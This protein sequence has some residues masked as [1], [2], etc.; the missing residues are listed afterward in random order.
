MLNISED[1]EDLDYYLVGGA[2]RDKIMGKKPEDEDFVV[3]GETKQS[4]IDRGFKYIQ[5]SSSYPVFLDSKKREFAL[6]RA[7]ESK[8]AGYGDFKFDT[9]NVSLEEDLRRRDFTMNAIAMDKNGNIVDPFNGR[10]DINRGI[11]RHVSSAFK[12]D[13]LRVFRMARFAARFDFEVSRTTIE[14]SKRTAPK[15]S[16]LPPQRIRESIR[17]AMKQA[18]EPSKFFKI[19]NRVDAYQ[20]FSREISKMTDDNIPA[21]PKKYHQE[22]SLWNHTLLVVD[23]M[24]KIDDSV[25]KLLMAFFHDIGKIKTPSSE[26][27]NHYGH[28]KEGAKVIDE[29][30]KSIKF[31][32]ETTRKL[33]EACKQHMRINEIEKE[34]KIIRLTERLDSNSPM[35][36]DD[37]IDLVEA[38]SRGSI[39]PGTFNRK[40]LERKINLARK[41]IN[42]IDG[43]YIL[44]NFDVEEGE[45]VG[46]L[47]LQERTK[48]LKKIS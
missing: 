40:E 38:D 12:E 15:I 22:G 13:P 7:E 27:P 25:D 23:E 46:D 32:T 39:G 41:V 42:K 18:E 34:S 37:L 1:T 11:I 3:V 30:R 33:K 44:N 4:M 31:S 45:K 29:L 43:N 26:Y 6:A 14:I 28:D 9:E 2:V 19:L 21:G 10:E 48:E 20:F 5:A 8:G 17:K 16:S 35:K 36:T 47:L 24:N